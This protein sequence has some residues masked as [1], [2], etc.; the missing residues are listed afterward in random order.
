MGQIL[1]RRLKQEKFSSVEQQGL[2]NLFIA[3]NYLHAKLDAI[4]CGFKITLAQFNVLR[5]LKGAHPNG[6]PRHEIIRR[7]V[8]PAPDVTR[9]IDR[10]MKEGLV[11]RFYSD[12]DR[13]LSLARITKKGITLLTRINPEVDKFISDYSSS[14]NKS[15]K[16]MLS[17]ICEKLY[18]NDL[19]L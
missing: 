8:E 2:L 10:L 1:K 16:E 11:E 14:L 4:C 12:E 3:S 7:M 6:Y 13:R 18:A 19:K 17:S 9:L 15:E 5:I